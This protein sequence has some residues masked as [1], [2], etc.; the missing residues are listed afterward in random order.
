MALLKKANTYYAYFRDLDG[1][2]VKR[3]LHTGDRAVAEMREKAMKAE[4]QEVK[5]R[6]AIQRM[7]PDEPQITTAFPKK[8]PVQGEHQRGSIALEK[9]WELALT[10]RDLSVTHK[11]HWNSFIG[12]VGKQYADEITPQVALAY[13]E[14]HYNKGNGKTFN[15]VKSNLN[16]VFRLCLVEAGLPESPFAPI[17]NRKVVDVE[18]HRN[19]TDEEIDLIMSAPNVAGYVRIMTML[20]RWTTQR[21]ETCARI[22]P[23]MF[24][25]EKKVF[26]I[27]PG[28]NSR[29]KEWVCCP[30]FPALEEYI[31]PILE[32]CASKN[33]PIVQYF[34][35]P[36]KNDYFSAEFRELLI[37][38]NI[39]DNENGKASFHSLRGT[40]ITW[41]KE[42]GV[43]REARRS[44]TGHDSQE[45]EDV[46]ARDI[47][48]ISRLAMGWGKG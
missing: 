23:S 18:H 2:Q 45:I 39:R 7:R 38:L 22:T 26:L 17:A 33:K 10:R 6:A 41:L 19:L 14:K 4:I 31:K 30:I 27:N 9:M 11:K 37:R 3:S 16:T 12:R 29:F 28:K 44:I 15:N 5:F 24:D 20:S 8:V 47:A 43:D 35:Y 34:N 25:F 48:T 40:A 46:Y 21:L 13:L 42:N 32:L 1:R 36:K